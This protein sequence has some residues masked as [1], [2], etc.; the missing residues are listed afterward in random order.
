MIFHHLHRHW[1]HNIQR[2]N[3]AEPPFPTCKPTERVEVDR[4]DHAPIG[5]GAVDT[6]SAGQFGDCVFCGLGYWGF[7]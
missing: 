6:D 3:H 1:T 7:G 2:V 5:S 4:S